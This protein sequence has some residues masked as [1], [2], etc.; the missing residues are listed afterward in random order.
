MLLFGGASLITNQVVI[1]SL[2]NCQ[3]SR[4]RFPWD[5]PLMH[6]DAW[7]GHKK[8]GAIYYIDSSG[9]LRVLYGRQGTYGTFPLAV[10]VAG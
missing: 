9:G 8:T 5:D 1:Y 10:S 4:N 3:G 7:T 2:Y 6:V